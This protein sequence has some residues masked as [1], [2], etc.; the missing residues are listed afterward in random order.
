MGA[1]WLAR[2]TV[3]DREVAVKRIGMVPGSDEADLARAE[4]E[5][6]LAAML[7]H[8]NVVAIFDLVEDHDDHWLVMEYVEGTTLASI[9]T[10]A[11]LPGGRAAALLGQVAEALAVAHETGVVHRDVKPS[12][13]LV[14]E[15]GTA[16][17]ADFGI[18]R[19]EADPSLTQTGL[20]T[21]SPAYLAPE[22]ASGGPATEAS[23]VWSL[24]ATLY[25]ALAGRPPY[26]VHDN[27]LGAMYRIVHD[28]TPRL[29]EPGWLGP[30]LEGTMTKDPHQRWSMTEVRDFLQSR[31]QVAPP[32]PAD[33]GTRTIHAVAPAPPPDDHPAPVAA[34]GRRARRRT[35]GAPVLAAMVAVVL[36]GVLGW[37]WLGP[38]DTEP[39]GTD[40]A[41]ASASEPDGQNAQ[42]ASEQSG[43]DAKGMRR[44]VGDYLAT[45]TEQPQRAFEMLT[46]GFQQ[47][48]G[49]FSGYRD[50]WGTIDEATITSF[51]A[52]PQDLTVRYGVEYVRT[53]G[54]TWS[55]EVQLQLT[56][57]G[58]SYRIAGEA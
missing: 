22:V 28:P 23:D 20:V 58:G 48:S 36:V 21:G 37:Q 12:N 26:E 16:K 53:D 50:F 8:P 54:S 40:T 46:P 33:T 17:L 32:L 43:P 1:V 34:P 24:G 14:T 19:A 38:S 10:D 15:D 31:G 27:V 42:N 25:H 55:D 49:N 57:R 13:I 30:V 51:E 18:A 6:R 41:R 9:I 44:F 35:S 5:A 29:D 3:L 56:Y 47:A 11:A 2:D 4:R 7:N 39:E 52:D 45:V